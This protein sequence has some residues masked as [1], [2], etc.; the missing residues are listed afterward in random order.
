MERLGNALIKV[1]ADFIVKFAFETYESYRN[2]DYANGVN[3]DPRMLIDKEDYKQILISD[4][5]ED[6]SFDSDDIESERCVIC[7]DHKKCCAIDPCGHMCLC[8]CCTR[9]LWNG[10]DQN[11]YCPVCRCQVKKI[12]RIYF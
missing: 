6:L 11:V 1:A 2:A 12:L 3:S 4:Y 5:G 10:F 8:V 7:I 9:S